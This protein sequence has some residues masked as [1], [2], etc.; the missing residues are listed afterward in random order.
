V[1]R[2]RPKAKTTLPTGTQIQLV[3][4]MGSPFASVP[5]LA[6][7]T[8]RAARAAL[9]SQGFA[10]RRTYAPS[11]TIRKGSVIGLQPPTG[12]RLHRPAR[13]TLVVASGYPRAVVPD[14]RNSTLTSAKGRLAAV[15]LRYRL[16]WQLTDAAAPGQ[17]LDQIPAAGTSVYQGAQIRLTI[18][19]TL[20]WVKL[21]SSSG[22]NSFDSNP[23][24]A[25]GRWRIRYR[26]SP[27]AF[28]LALAQFGWSGTDR[29][30]GSSFVATKAGSLQTY[31]PSVGAGSYTVGVRPFAGAGWYVEVD[32]LK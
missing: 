28:G 26:L 31:V 17:V 20:H 6:G 21:F 30:S 25:S 23:F 3:V 29:N 22:S 32:V 10:S 5:A 2:Q 1:I 19:R 18:A 13:V 8:E 12:T 16:V 7:R 27:N 9:A 14:V 24:S 11:W 4:S 15:G